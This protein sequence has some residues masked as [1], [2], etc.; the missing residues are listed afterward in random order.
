MSLDLCVKLKFLVLVL[1]TGAGLLTAQSSHA[2]T[3]RSAAGLDQLSILIALTAFRQDLGGNLN[4]NVAGSF[5][6]GRREINWDA[7][8]N[9]FASPNNLPLNFFNVN[10]PRGAVFNTPGTGVQVSANA[11]PGP[12]EFGNINA[13]YPGLFE[14]FSP[15]RLFAPIGSNMVDVLFFVPGSNTPAL[16]NGFG[17][18]FTDVDLLNTT[19]MSFF[20]VNNNLLGTFFAPALPGDETFSFLGVSFA[21]SQ[22][23]RVRITLGNSPFGPN[24]TPLLDIVALDDF[25]YGEPRSVAVVPIPAVGAGLP[26]L[27]ALGGFVVWARRRKAAA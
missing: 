21:D 6:S 24:E 2:Q 3:V 27:L 13:T 9:Q 8:P 19:S 1:A 26:A 20:G 18:V 15:Q 14:T 23:S 17:A 10:S 12:I 11:V 25:I 4:P 22:I 16:T 5:P 7:V